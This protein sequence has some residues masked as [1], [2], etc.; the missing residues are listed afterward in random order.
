[1][2]LWEL[3]AR[4]LVRENLYRYNHAGD[5]GRAQ[6]LAATFAEDGVLEI[7]GGQQYTGRAAIAEFI[8]GVADRAG[9]SATP[10][11]EQ[12]AA[13]LLRH[14]LVN[15]L[16]ASITPERAEVNSYFVVFMRHGLDHCGR[17]RDVLVPSGDRWLF[18]HRIVRTDA[19]FHTA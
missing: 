2:E 19:H 3:S 13:P 1:M 8:G 10:S 7:F 9:G 18:Q 17:Y 5:R 16:F 6:E 14:C 11:P 4:E 15:S 12:L